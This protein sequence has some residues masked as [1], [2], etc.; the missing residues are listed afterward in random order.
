MCSLPHAILP[1]GPGS[2]TPNSSPQPHPSE[3]SPSPTRGRQLLQAV[4][5]IRKGCW[6]SSTGLEVA[7]RGLAV[8]QVKNV[9]AHKALRLS[10]VS[11]FCSLAL[12]GVPTA[13][14]AVTQCVDL[15]RAATSHTAV[16]VP[17]RVPDLQHSHPQLLPPACQSLWPRA[18]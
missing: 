5:N 6:R 16:P 11:W 18:E 1:P 2:Q 3:S 17:G 8:R 15:V 10:P 14:H 12:L 9:T 13:Q 4:G 7:L